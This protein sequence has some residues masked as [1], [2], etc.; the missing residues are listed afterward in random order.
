MAPPGDGDR[1]T[2]VLPTWPGG[3]SLHPARRHL[4]TSLAQAIRELI[5]LPDNY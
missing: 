4:V 2:R 3:L 1:R 5:A